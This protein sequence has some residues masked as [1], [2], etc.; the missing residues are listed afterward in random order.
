MLENIVLRKDNSFQFY[1][2]VLAII[3][4]SYFTISLLFD[5]Y[6]V[7]SYRH[8]SAYYFGQ[9]TFYIKLK[10]EGRWINYLLYP[11]YSAIPGKLAISLDLLFMFLFVFTVS[12]RWTN[13][14]AYAFVL[15]CLFVQISPLIQQFLWP[16]TILPAFLILYLAVLV[17]PSTPVYVFYALFG[18]LLFGTMSYLYYLLPLVH[19]GLLGSPSIKKN[20]TTLF[21]K[22]IPAWAIGFIVG[23]AFTL[24]VIYISSG[25][26]GIEIAGWRRPNYVENFEDVMVNTA[27]SFGYMQSH[28]A[29]LFSS[30]E[31]SIMMAAALAIG[32]MG[33]KK[34]RYIP[35]VIL[36]LAVAI[37]HY[38]IT[39][40]VGIII[41]FRTATSAWLGVLMIFFFYP[42]IKKWQY[43]FLMPIVLFMTSS[44]Y[45]VNHQ[46][47]RWYSSITNIYY[48]ELLRAT[49]LPPELYNGVIF[50]GSNAEMKE[51]NSIISSRLQLNRGEMETLNADRR[52]VP[53]GY[54]A[55]FKHVLLCDTLHKRNP[56]CKKLLQESKDEPLLNKKISGFYQILGQRDGYLIISLNDPSTF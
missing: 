31:R 13:N 50:L 42:A 30:V 8:D 32:Y 35:M 46:S 15:S 17:S 1:I 20:Y 16:A 41:Q 48:N 28:I 10:Q 55:G 56:T 29:E 37:V 3:V 43:Y 2:T 54:E 7:H 51:V 9:D 38:I 44:L 14:I 49:P 27:K 19:F 22:L 11:V 18:V 33:T 5:F 6:Q 39:I 4:G 23:Y 47:L 40:P 24:L 26:V 53:V 21:L 12:A 36:S 52:W 25:H 34:E 45:A